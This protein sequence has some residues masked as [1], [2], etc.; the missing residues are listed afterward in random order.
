MAGSVIDRE[1]SLLEAHRTS[2][3]EVIEDKNRAL[4]KKNLVHRLVYIGKLRNEV[5]DRNEVGNHYERL[6]KNLMNNFQHSEPMTGL[7]LVYMKHLIHVIE[8]S[9]D[10]IREVMRDIE[11][12]QKGQDGFLEQAK[13]LVISH[14]INNRLYQQWNFRTLDI[15]AA[16]MEAYESSEGADKI[17]IDMLSQMLKLGNKLSIT[18]KVAFKSALDSL[19]EKFPDLLP[20]QGHIHFLMEE[21]DSSMILPD[22]YL[23]MYDKPYDVVLESEMVWPLPTKLFPYN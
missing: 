2:L 17:I 7:L 19:H 14:D 4:S 12:C 9:S 1:D 18:P 16:R 22:E 5:E 6:L 21:N 10:M 13:I 8:A 3:L 23:N 11:T 20:Q 15:Q